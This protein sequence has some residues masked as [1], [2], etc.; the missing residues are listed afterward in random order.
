MIVY[1]PLSRLVEERV[2]GTDCLLAVRSSCWGR[3]RLALIVY[4][5]FGG[6]VGEA[7]PA[8][9]LPEPRPAQKRSNLFGSLWA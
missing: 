3:R 5:P 8:A 9:D 4:W 6:L 7:A 1:W 2:L